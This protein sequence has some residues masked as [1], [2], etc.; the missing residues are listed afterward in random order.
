M[1][2]KLLGALLVVCMVLA[3]LPVTSAAATDYNLYVGGVKVTSDN[4]S[5]ITGSGISG[6]VSFDYSTK[7]LTLNNATITEVYDK[8]LDMFGIWSGYATTIHLIGQN[9]VVGKE[10]TRDRGSTYAIYSLNTLTFSGSGSL[11]AKTGNA[12]GSDTNNW[13]VGIFASGKMT[14]GENCTIIASCGDADTTSAIMSYSSVVIPEDM[15]VI[16]SK[17]TSGTPTVPYKNS[18]ISTYKY[19]KISPT[20]KHTVTFDANGGSGSMTAVSVAEG[21]E[22]TLPEC[23]FTAPQGK[24]FKAW[25]V[26]GADKNV[27]DTI[28]L[29]QNVTVTAVWENL[30]AVHTC[31]PKAVTKVN[32]SCTA[33]GK[34]A[35]Y[36]CEGCGKFYSDAQGKNVI[37]NISTWGILNK[38]EHTP[39]GWKSNDNTHW[40]ECT[41]T[42]CGTVIANTQAAHADANGDGKCDTCQSAMPTTN[43]DA[44][45]DTTTDANTDVSTDAGSEQNT[46]ASDS[47]T[48]GNAPADSDDAQS[49]ES[50]DDTAPT[51][52]TASDL[53]TDEGGSEGNSLAWLWILLGVAGAAIVAVAVIFLLKKK[54]NK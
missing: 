23:G 32:P 36:K 41:A 25:K 48:S 20:V 39:S 22:Y 15:T 18:D 44:S 29:S 43:T 17:N 26:N 50:N 3:W 11:T 24:K 9:T 37:A 1:K 14:I 49:T 21:I 33:E 16:A 30:P 52:G 4:A 51:V 45:D 53:S 2:K 27:G 28:T 47:Q 34:E 19:M 10:H 31:S 8:S 54:S 12:L 5:N 13:S 46:D 6:S 35:Y 40:K 7:T 38:T 42:A